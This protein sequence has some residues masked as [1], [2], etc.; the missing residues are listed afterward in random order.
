MKL[1]QGLFKE[2]A[3]SS[4]AVIFFDSFITGFLVFVVLYFLFTFFRIDAVFAFLPVLIGFLFSFIR[5]LR[6]NKVVDIEQHYPQLKEMLR[7][8]NDY[9]DKSNPVV[10][11]LHTEVIN[12]ASVID[13]VALL[14]HKKL[15]WKFFF[16]SVMLFSTLVIASSGLHFF[17]VSNAISKSPLMERIRDAGRRILPEEFNFELKKNYSENPDIAQLT[18]D[19]L[20]ITL[21]IYNTELDINEITP[22]EKNDF[23]GE[24]PESIGGIAQDIYSDKIPQE[25]KETIKDYFDKIR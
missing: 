10:L 14:N 17:D 24:Y 5:K 9:K 8:S 4:L 19:E 12:K 7:T 11:A 23:G 15:F 20:N 13:I 22:P 1:V 3:I 16:I 21:D 25:H 2:I 18:E 6:R